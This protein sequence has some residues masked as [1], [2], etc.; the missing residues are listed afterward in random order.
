MKHTTVLALCI[1]VLIG[2]AAVL[3]AQPGVLDRSFDPKEQALGANGPGTDT[4]VNALA[5]Q[6]DGKILIGGNFKQY[7]GV[8]RSYV[9]RLNPDGSLDPSFHPGKGPNGAVAVLAPQPDGKILI[10]GAFTEYDGVARPYIARLSPDGSLDPSFNAG[11]LV[12]SLAHPGVYAIAVQPDKKIL[13]G[14]RFT[15]Y[16]GVT[17]RYIARLNPDGSLDPSFDPGGSIGGPSYPEVH[18]LALQPDGKILV[19]GE[20]TQYG[21][22]VRPGIARL[23]PNGSLDLSFEPGNGFNNSSVYTFLLQPNGKILIGGS[24]V[25]YDGVS[26]GSNLAR[27]NPDGSLDPS[28][29]HKVIPNSTVHALAQHS[30]GK[31]FI[32][33]AFNEYGNVFRNHIA[34]LNSDGSLDHSFNPGGGPDDQVYALA[35]QPDGKALIGGWFTT[36]ESSVRRHVARVTS[37]GS[38]DPS[39]SPGSGADFSVSAFGLQSDGKILIGGDFTRYNDVERYRVARLNVDGSLDYS[40]DPAGGANGRVSAFAIQP[41]G[42]ILIGGMFTEY[43]GVSRR[44]IARLNSD[45]RLDA[46]FDPGSGADD[47]IRFLFLQPDGKIL[48]SG[49][50]KNYNGVARQGIARL[51]ADGSL[52]LSFDLGISLSGWLRVFALQPDG[53]ILA[54]ETFI[55]PGNALRARVI[56][57]NADGS[58][59]PSFDPRDGANSW[60]HTLVLQPDGKILIGGSFTQ[61]DGVARRRIARLNADGSLDASFD[62]GNNITGRVDLLVLQPDGKTLVRR[63]SSNESASLVRLNS[64]GSIDP[65]FDPGSGVNMA[66]IALALQPDGKILIGG[67]FTAYNGV[68]RAGVARL[69]ADASLDPFFNSGAGP[70]HVVRALV[71]QSDGKVLV[72]GDFTRASGQYRHRIA[73]FNDDGSVD[74]SFHPDI[75]LGADSGI[76][77][78]ALY[79]DEKKILIG[80]EFTRYNRFGHRGVTRLNADGSRDFSFNPAG[81]GANGRVRALALSPSTGQILIA[82]DFTAYNGVPRRYLARLNADGT[83]DPSFLPAP[84]PNRPVK[85]LAWLPD[86][87]ILIAGEFTAYNGVFRPHIARLS[88]NGALDLTFNRGAGTDG[89]IH[90]LALQP[91]GKILIGGNFTTYNGNPRN[92]ITRLNADG[93]LDATFAP[94]A[95]GPNGEVF[96]LTVQPDGKILIGGNFSRY[97][98]AAR[99]GI[100]RL[101]PDGTLD[102]AFGVGQGANGPVYALA[103]RPDGRVYIGGAFT[104]YNGVLSNHLA[105]LHGD[106]TSSVVSPVEAPL[107][108]AL[109]PNPATDE[110]WLNVADF[111]GERISIAVHHANG[112]LALLRE[113]ERAPDLPLTLRLREAGLAGGTYVFC[114]R[115]A[116]R[117]AIGRAVLVEHR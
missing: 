87:Q 31:I 102:S 57:L 17:R 36:Y 12:G 25:L 22:I 117:T 44:G 95:G 96:T 15:E 74:G 43:N 109:W 8:A 16:G 27:L 79:P 33:G 84:G 26:V 54:V 77:A 52:D 97:D 11:G 37:N 99:P 71:H 7:N 98:G 35:V 63:S 86:G 20:F 112:Q 42:S 107:T 91:D 55:T 39:F 50:F 2:N 69:N 66:I 90:A 47:A 85:A 81:A 30:D 116:T 40:F 62:P 94:L 114:V 4:W 83:L 88:A 113:I 13:I 108:L 49:I 115:S 21:G 41:D 28:F 80:G 45:G 67:D 78:L 89:P 100:A 14:G 105:R 53:K 68:Y 19:G 92:F 46:S 61:Y 51:N 73:R 48:I 18:V 72:A 58:Q 111:A 104:N 3:C 23:H 32:A 101:N 93:A 24:F 70:N 56:R 76:Y 9:A 64:D 106:K 59:D 110:I 6:A 75:T 29:A 65:S 60:I 1:A 5:L 103:L 82:G 34:R 38:L 10:G